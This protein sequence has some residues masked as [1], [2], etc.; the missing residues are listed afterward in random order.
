[1]SSFEFSNTT[2]S[3]LL[4]LEGKV[5]MAAAS[6]QSTQSGVNIYLNINQS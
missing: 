1:V 3:E 4:H 2:S 6:V 5:A